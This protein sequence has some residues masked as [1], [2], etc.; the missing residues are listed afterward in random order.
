MSSIN[1]FLNNFKIS[2]KLRFI[3]LLA[4][5]FI[6]SIGA[7][8]AYK[9]KQESIKER[10]L[11]AQSLVET[12]VAQ[13]NHLA[14][15][16]LPPE[17]AK[18]LAIELVSSVRYSTNGYF[19]INDLDG[20]MI[21]HPIKP[22]LNGKSTIRG[23][24]DY[25][26]N[27][28]SEFIR[29]AKRDSA[30]FIDYDWPIPGSSELESKISYVEKLDN[31]PWLIGTGVYFSD[32]EE[33]FKEELISTMI[34]TAG[35]ILILILVS[36]LISRNIIKPLSK[37]TSTM[38]LI[39]E[40]KDLTITMKGNGKDE[41]STMAN[42]FNQMNSNIKQVVTNINENTSSLASQ[43]EE[44]STVTMQI[45]GGIIEQ[46]AQTQ[47]VAESVEQLAQSAN[48]VAEKANTVLGTTKD[49]TQIVQDGNQTITEN[50]AVISDV[51]QKVS[52]AVVTVE[53]LEKSSNQIGEILEVIKQIAD[54]TNLLAL[55]AA[56]EAARAGEQGRG[57]AVVADEVRTLASRTQ[58]STGSI[59]SIISDLQ[60]GV[61]KTVGVMR[62]CEAQTDTSIEKANISGQALAQIQ[63]AITT[64][65]GMVQEINHA[66]ESQHVQVT[67]ISSNITSIAAVAEQSEIGTAQT[68]QSSEQLS[69]M[70][71]ELNG[72]VNSF[73]V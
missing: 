49:V 36:I 17:Q 42:A 9:L 50:I 40:E 69:Q 34:S 22:E 45:Q 55:N 58:E 2:Y 24:Q 28:F 60:A 61:H 68:S 48:N 15:S 62:S 72:L 26:R 71:Q 16:N 14:E 25:M 44:L 31:L 13:L 43:A 7:L 27:A 67:E 4:S 30:G 59:N 11:A 35:I 66:A 38:S 73:K 70:A 32:V 1:R 18:K 51:A 20:M 54:Q 29:V 57:F 12:V 37:I 21:M 46:K 5:L 64:L 10:K 52:E 6:L 23:T 56:I 47:A 53:D 19:W 8:S 63:D 41:L 65:D 33:D 3:I 39:A